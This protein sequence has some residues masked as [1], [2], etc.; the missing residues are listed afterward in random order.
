MSVGAVTAPASPSNLAAAGSGARVTVTWQAPSTGDPPSSYVLEAG[1]STGRADIANFDTGNITPSFVANNVPA[2]TYY[3]R[4]RAKNAA[5]VSAPSN[6]V[7]VLVIPPCTSPPVAPT[8]LRSTVTGSTVFLTWTP[9][10]G[11][12]APTSYV[13]QAGASAGASNL[14]DFDNRSLA[15][16]F[17]ASGVEVG[18]YFVRVRAITTFAT[19]AASNEVVVVVVAPPLATTSFVA[20]GDS[21][22]AGESGLNSLPLTTLLLTPSRFHRTVLVPLNQR[23]PTVLQQEL[24]ARYRT[25]FPTVRNEGLGGEAVTDSWTLTRFRTVLFSA[26]YGAVLIMEGTNDLADQDAPRIV[27]AIAG[28]RQMVR[29]AKARGVKPYLATIPPMNPRGFRV[30]V[31]YSWQSVP[32]LN[33]SIRAL[34]ASESVK[35]VDVNQAFNNDFGLLGSDGL[36]PNADGY[37]RIA[38]TFYVAI[39]TTLE[40]SPSTAGAEGGFIGRFR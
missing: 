40:A 27:G 15:T 8:N 28:L 22:T 33:D 35:L 9:P 26:G 31:E 4:V 37:A 34:A 2:A 21:I 13:I 18:Q 14:A 24:A 19:G 16:S 11:G 25:Q 38:D 7:V 36:H 12:C 20:F 39:K 5:G 29:D 23:Y 32:Q 10:V 3:V 30:A 6:E 17:T 1:S